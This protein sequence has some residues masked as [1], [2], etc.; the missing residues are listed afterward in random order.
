MG[1]GNETMPI[2]YSCTSL[3]PSP[4]RFSGEGSG[5]ETTAVLIVHGLVPRPP[6]SFPSLYRTASDGKLGGGLGTKLDCPQYQQ[7]YQ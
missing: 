1:D 7:L 5:D 2:L 6:P 4:F 3:V